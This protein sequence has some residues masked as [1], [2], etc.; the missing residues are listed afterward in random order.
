LAQVFSSISPS[1]QWSAIQQTMSFQ[2]LEFGA[3]RTSCTAKAQLRQWD[4]EDSSCEQ[5]IKVNIQKMQE[6]VRL[7]N[8]HLERTQ[9]MRVSKRTIDTL[10]KAL[11]RSQDLVKETEQLFRDW[12]VHLAGEPR[13][14]H[15]KKFVYEKLERS[16]KEEVSNLKAASRCATA[17]HKAAVNIEARGSMEKSY[18]PSE[19]EHCLLAGSEGRRLSTLGEDDVTILALQ[20]AEGQQVMSLKSIPAEVLS[21]P[22]GAI[23][24]RKEPK[25]NAER[26]R[27]P[28]ERL[29]C[30][31]G[32]AMIM[33]YFMAV[34]HH[35]HP[36]CVSLLRLAGVTPESVSAGASV[37]QSLILD[38]LHLVRL[39]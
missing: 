3:Q 8:E 16:F 18:F 13:V 36:H 39:G 23:S 33:I 31:F 29:C 5:Q 21:R 4:R 28:F 24:Y 12:I 38:R 37:H 22:L 32:L 11:D 25:A 15:I 14:R 9:R 27:S 26:R 6:S 7:A 30:G 17:A 35:L 19:E 34:L 1:Q 2:D 10:N 20:R